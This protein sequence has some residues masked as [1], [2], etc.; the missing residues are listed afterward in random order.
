M[1]PFL[2]SGLL[3]IDQ[4]TSILCLQKMDKAMQKLFRIS[5]VFLASMMISIWTPGSLHASMT[6]MQTQ[7]Q[8]DFTPHPA[9]AGLSIF[10]GKTWVAEGDGF[11]DSQTWRWVNKGQAILIEHC[12]NVDAYCGVSLIH[13]DEKA[14]KVVFRYATTGGFF[15]DGELTVTE[16]G[17]TALEKVISASG[18][19]SQAKSG[20]TV[21]D[22]VATIWSQFEIDQKWGDKDITIYKAK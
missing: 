9:L 16:D 5:A 20:A 15:T 21:K 19:I 12:V 22:G 10:V 8:S 11:T 17:Y 2:F 3:R 6:E 14:E 4:A 7:G 18:Q 13:Y 1:A